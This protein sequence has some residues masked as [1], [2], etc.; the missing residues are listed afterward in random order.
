MHVALRRVPPGSLGCR[1]LLRGPESRAPDLQ[2]QASKRRWRCGQLSDDS[3]EIGTSESLKTINVTL[4][5]GTV[6]A[7]VIQ[8]RI[9][10]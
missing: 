3:S 9:L 8:L 2:A 4:F 5:E 6:L 7:D 10:R 1:R